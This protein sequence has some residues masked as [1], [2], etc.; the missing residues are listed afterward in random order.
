MLGVRSLELTVD[1]DRSDGARDFCSGVSKRNKD[2]W[3]GVCGSS[4]SGVS[5]DDLEPGTDKS[6]CTA[7]TLGCLPTP[8][9]SGLL[10]SLAGR[11]AVRRLRGGGCKERAPRDKVRVALSLLTGG[12]SAVA[13]WVGCRSVRILR[14]MR[15]SMRRS[16]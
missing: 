12:W 1:T 3:F 8:E 16:I 9:E 5:M 2:N 11:V 14:S 10:S 7:T 6:P 4:V 13:H 15:R